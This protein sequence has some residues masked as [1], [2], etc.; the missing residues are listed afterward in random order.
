M[1]AG[2][3]DSSI[4]VCRADFFSHEGPKGSAILNDV[5]PSSIDLRPTRYFRTPHQHA[6]KKPH[7]KA[8][9]GDSGSPEE[10]GNPRFSL[11]EWG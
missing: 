10:R 9:G 2:S 4:V 8:R 1:K 6:C 11:E 7:G 5:V 3:S